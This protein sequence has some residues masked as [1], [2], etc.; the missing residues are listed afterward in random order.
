MKLTSCSSCQRLVRLADATCPFCKSPVAHAGLGAVVPRVRRGLML[1]GAAA[2]SVSCGGT[3]QP[4]YGMPSP[5][6]GITQDAAPDGPV[7]M[8]GGPPLDGGL[9]AAK[10]AAPD[11][12]IAAYGGPPLDSGKD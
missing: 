1:V 9:D 5:D 10:D 3:A 6:G 7:A 2:I 12:P 11:G 8:Y 4:A